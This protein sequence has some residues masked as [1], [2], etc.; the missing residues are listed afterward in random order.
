MDFKKLGK[1]VGQLK[2]QAEDK[3]G[4]RAEPDNLKRDG[5]EL[6]NIL[7]GDGSLADKAKEAKA[8]VIDRDKPATGAGKPDP[9]KPA[10]TPETPKGPT[11]GQ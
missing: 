8:K 7:S 6:R 5:K 4:D 10:G 1:Q 3:L 11:G 2:K 9:G